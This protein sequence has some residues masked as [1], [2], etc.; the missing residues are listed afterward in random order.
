M[1]IWKARRMALVARAGNLHVRSE[2]AYAARTLV[3]RSTSACAA[4]RS[5][6]PLGNGTLIQPIPW[7]AWPRPGRRPSWN[8]PAPWRCHDTKATMMREIAWIRLLSTSGERG[9]ALLRP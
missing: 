8:T 4:A 3:L 7:A 5:C 1:L 2:A 6:A 9:L